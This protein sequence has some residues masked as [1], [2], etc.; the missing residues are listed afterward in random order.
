[1]Q[2]KRVSSVKHKLRLIR[3]PSWYVEL[4]VPFFSPLVVA[5]SYYD[6]REG[7]VYFLAT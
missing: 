1:M 4:L 2:I 3:H 6:L 7:K 5:T